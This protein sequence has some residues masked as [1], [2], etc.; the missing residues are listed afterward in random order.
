MQQQQQLI[1]ES[2]TRRNPGEEN[3][4]FAR[5]ILSC[6]SFLFFFLPSQN[7]SPPMLPPLP[8]SPPPPPPPPPP[9]SSGSSCSARLRCS[10]FGVGVALYLLWLPSHPV[11]PSPLLICRRAVRDAGVCVCEGPWM[12]AGGERLQRRADGEAAGSGPGAPQRLLGLILLQSMSAMLDA[13]L[14]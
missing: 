4:P 9:L 3:L 2:T 6:Q 10:F 5:K 8:P 14:T 1:H 7:L 11:T 13:G 12:K